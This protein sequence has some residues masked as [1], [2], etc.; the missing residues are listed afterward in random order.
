MEFIQCPNPG[1]KEQS[2][3]ELKNGIQP[4]SLAITLLVSLF[5]EKDV[6]L[7]L[8]ILLAIPEEKLRSYQAHLSRVWN[9]WDANHAYMDDAKHSAQSHT[10][11]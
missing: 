4:R 5:K 7:T 1:E 2:P 11:L 10:L 8:E 9:R 3:D 6:D